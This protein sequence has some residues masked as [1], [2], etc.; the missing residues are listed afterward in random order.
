MISVEP[1]TPIRGLEGMKQMSTTIVPGIYD[2]HFPDRKLM[3]DTEDAYTAVKRLA[4]EEGFCR[5][6]FGCGITWHH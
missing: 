4:A 3:V 5:I 2:E 6:F 1:S